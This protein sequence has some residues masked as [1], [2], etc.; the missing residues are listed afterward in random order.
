MPLKTLRKVILAKVETTAG[1]DATPAAATDALLVRNWQFNPL[2]L[3]LEGRQMV[4]PYFGNDG[5][6]IAGKYCQF[7]FEI[8]MAGAGAAG[9][10]PKYDAALQACALSATNSPGVSQVYAPVTSGEKT[11]TFCFYQDGILHKAVYCK[12]D[13]GIKMEAGK[14]PAFTFS[15]FGIFVAV[16][17]VALVSPTLSGFT[18]PLPVNNANTTPMTLDAYA[19][20]FASLSLSAGNQ[21][22]YRNLVGAEYVVF[23]DRQ[24]KG[25]ISMEKP[26]IGTKDFYA[27]IQAGATKALSV[28]HG[29]T[30]GNKVTV[31]A[32]Q[33]Q[34]TSASES[35]QDGIAMLTLGMDLLPSSAGNDEFSITVI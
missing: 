15:F 27:I 30:A 20:V 10:I 6:M 26:L 21:M 34:L 28:T 17:D 3:N 23:M 31:A 14:V 11:A 13:V 2:Q 18:K 4:L 33:A 35:D 32:G 16:T 24:S 12:G 5:Q 19:G 8:E 29:T 1:T 25:S 7:Q 9:S 22:K